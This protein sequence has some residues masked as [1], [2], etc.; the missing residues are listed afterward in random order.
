[1]EKKTSELINDYYR[2][3][4]YSGCPIPATVEQ[5]MSMNYFQ[6]LELSKKRPELYQMMM[7]EARKR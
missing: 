5:F 4:P 1:M 2:N 7:E 3:S 6:R